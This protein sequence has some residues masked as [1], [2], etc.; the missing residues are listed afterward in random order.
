MT[1]AILGVSAIAVM[2]FAACGSGPV[3]EK[4]EIFK[5][6][7]PLLADTVYTNE[8]VA[9]INALQNVELR[10]RIAGFVENVLADEGQAV[11]QG[12]TLFVISSRKYRQELQ[13][14]EAAT[15]SARAKLKAA[16]IELENARKLFAKNII[17]RSELDLAKARIEVEKA[18]VSEAEANEA[19]ASLHLSLTEIKAPFDGVINRIPNKTGSLVEEGT[20]LTTISNN[21]EMFAYFNVSEKDYLDYVFSKDDPKSEEVSLVLVNGIPHNHTGKIETVESEFDPSTGNI[22]FRA[23][24]LNPDGILKHGASGKVIVKKQVKDAL[25]IPQKSTFEIQDKLYVFVVSKDNVL[26][27]RNIV[28]KMRLPHLYLVESG[29]SHNE[30]ILFEGVQQVRAGDKIEPEMVDRR[31]MTQLSTSR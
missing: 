13:R 6:T 31:D 11:R 17:A 5:V 26:E 15:K 2:L 3:G 16:E 23:R 1:R 7:T 9:E 14:A 18:D 20:L 27:Q 29:L 4:K 30:R 25:I 21:K 24:F 28:P 22:A 19:Q 10:S 8:Y 12:Q